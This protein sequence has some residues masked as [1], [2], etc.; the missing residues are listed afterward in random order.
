MPPWPVKESGLW[1][2]LAAL[3]LWG[4]TF[5]IFFAFSRVKE[6]TSATIRMS[7]ALLLAVFIAAI[8]ILGP[9][10]FPLNGAEPSHRLL[11][12][13]ALLLAAL[14]AAFDRRGE[15][16]VGI[17][18]PLWYVALA[19]LTLEGVTGTFL[20][21]RLVPNTEDLFRKRVVQRWPYETE[22]EKAPGTYRILAL[23]DSFGIVHEDKNYLYEVHRRFE[24]EGT[25]AEIINFSIQA[26]EPN[27]QLKVLRRFGEEYHPD[28]VLHSFFIGNDFVIPPGE[29]V[30][31]GGIYVRHHEGL[32][33]FHP[34][35][36]L[37]VNWIEGRWKVL[38]EHAKR[39][40]EIQGA[41]PA[42]MFSRK[43]FLDIEVNR[44]VQ[45]S[46]KGEATQSHLSA[47]LPIL[48]DIRQI[49]LD[50]GA[51]Y[52]LVALPDQFQVDPALF[53]EILQEFGL[54]AEDFD[55]SHPQSV[56]RSYC[57]DRGIPF[58]D[59]L[60]AFRGDGR[61]GDLFLLRDTHFNLEGNAIVADRVHRF[62]LE[63]FIPETARESALAEPG[64]EPELAP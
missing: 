1:I 62:L 40:K 47:S 56:L 36:F 18:L 16:M 10:L 45:T 55:L 53:G 22:K 42:G 35:N 63:N 9:A 21:E 54:S 20:I 4:A 32:A 43:E 59:I 5:G 24:A 7:R 34:K 28:L 41:E 49:A 2:L 64:A 39:Q 29:F 44:L 19:L 31:L 33:G 23:G 3:A 57:V 12:L 25:H 48:D 26:I 14:L 13:S 17:A 37:L 11:L 58:L 51:D 8:L 38:S 6:S 52:A 61:G 15:W 60:E 30:T 27:D 50:M 46:K